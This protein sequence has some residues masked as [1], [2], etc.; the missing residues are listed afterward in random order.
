MGICDR[1]GL[2]ARANQPPISAGLSQGLPP[3]R[4]RLQCCVQWSQALRCEPNRPCLLIGPELW[5]SHRLRGSWYCR[6]RLITKAFYRAR[7]LKFP[8]ARVTSAGA[9]NSAPYAY[10]WTKIPAIERSRS[11]RPLSIFSMSPAL[12]PDL[13]LPVEFGIGGGPTAPQQHLIFQAIT[14]GID[15]SQVSERVCS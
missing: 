15:R 11:D 2:Q 5:K 12:I 1:L 9:H 14:T 8:M 6:E 3:V 13:I 10:F 4:L 7:R